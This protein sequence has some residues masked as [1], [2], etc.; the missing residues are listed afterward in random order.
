[1]HIYFNITLELFIVCTAV[2]LTPLIFTSM[3][4]FTKKEKMMMPVSYIF[5]HCSFSVQGTS[6][7]I[8][9]LGSWMSLLYIFMHLNVVF[10]NHYA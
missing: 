8:T 9:E 2:L 7:G 10:L 1:M 4:K 6:E 5:V 3:L